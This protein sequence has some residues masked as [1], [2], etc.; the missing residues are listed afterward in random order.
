[1]VKKK[2]RKRKRQMGME[3]NEYLIENN[4]YQSGVKIGRNKCI[5]RPTYSLNLRPQ[6]DGQNGQPG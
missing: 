5:Y 1:V 2:K 4:V 3:R 6:R